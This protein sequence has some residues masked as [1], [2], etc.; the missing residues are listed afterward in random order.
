MKFLSMLFLAVVSLWAQPNTIPTVSPAM[1]TVTYDLA[2]D[3][4][5]LVPAITVTAGSSASFFY[6]VNVP[7]NFVSVV[8]GGPLVGLIPPSNT[9]L[10]Q[11]AVNASSLTVGTYNIP[12]TFVQSNPSFS[13]S[14]GLTLVVVDSRTYVFLDNNSRMVPHIAAGSP[15]TTRL[16]FTN[17]TN[18]LQICDVRFFD[19]TG[20]AAS[21]LVAGVPTQYIPAVAVAANGYTDLVVDNTALKTGTAVI[22]SFMGGMPGINAIYLNSQ[23]N[24]ESAVEIKS[25]NNGTLRMVFDSVGRH[26]SGVAMG[27]SLNYPIT[28]TLQ[29]TDGNGV[30]LLPVGSAVPQVSIPANG[31]FIAVLDQMFPFLAQKTGVL[32]LTS[33]QPALT[34]FGLLFDL[35]NDGFYTQPA[36]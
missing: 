12:L 26:S 2:T 16:R 20:A 36:F 17:N 21:F 25:S 6:A 13:V 23:N 35:T 32:T 9:V 29:F 34:A 5:K 10:V 31:Q 11:F 33:S 7:S 14:V 8:Q 3:T 24:I 1:V 30:S 19:A 15:W 27:N 28:V 4:V 22:H 18:N